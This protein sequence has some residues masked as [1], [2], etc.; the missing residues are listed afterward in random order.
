[1]HSP[2]LVPAIFGLAASGATLLGG[3]LALRFAERMTL[4]IALCAGIVL[5]VALFDLLPEALALGAAD[6]R[7]RTIMATVGAGI[8]GYMVLSR[9]FA[10]SGAGRPGIRAHL[11]PASLTVHSFF[12]GLGIGLAFQISSGIGWLIAL[13]VLAHDVAD[14]VN[15]V[16]VSLFESDRSAARRWLITNAAAPFAGVVVGQV[17]HVSMALL[18]PLLAVFAGIFLYIGACELVPRSYARSPRLRTTLASLAGMTI[19]Y[20]VT[21]WTA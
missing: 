1:M 14:G 4:M 17:V 19:M 7:P 15:T 11:G 6:F 12:D 10:A 2:A 20:G 8:G 21:R 3:L 16:S 18:A 5:G 9:M 13:A